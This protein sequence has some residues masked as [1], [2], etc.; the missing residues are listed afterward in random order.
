MLELDDGFNSFNK[1]ASG[2]PAEKRK[3]W[4][5]EVLSIDQ[6]SEVFI[7]FVTRKIKK[8]PF[9]EGPMTAE[10]NDIRDV[11]VNFNK[12][13]IFTINSQPQVN[14]L[15]SSDPV[16]G[17]GPTKGFVFQKAYFEFFIPPE[18]LEPLINELK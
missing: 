9:S 17:W 10:S 16:Y 12:N 14:G 15:P 1:K 4:G 8:F 3:L 11:L 13:R 7:A 18:L 6:I 5:E 2:D